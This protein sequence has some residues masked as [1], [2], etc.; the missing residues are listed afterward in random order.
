M[1]SCS[2]PG[3][4]KSEEITTSNFKIDLDVTGSSAVNDRLCI[5]SAI[6]RSSRSNASDEYNM[7]L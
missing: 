2:F 5:D 6:C 3:D 4:F 1:T 7:E